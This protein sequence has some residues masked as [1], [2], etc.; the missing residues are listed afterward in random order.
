VRS[1]RCACTRG[2]RT[3]LRQQPTARA[4]GRLLPGS[5]AHGLPVAGGGGASC[6]DCT[7]RPGVGSRHRRGPES[8]WLPPSGTRANGRRLATGTQGTG[9]AGSGE[10][11]LSS[12]SSPLDT[13]R[14]RAR[15]RLLRGRSARLSSRSG[16]RRRRRPRDT[17]TMASRGGLGLAGMRGWRG[18]RRS[19]VFRRRRNHRCEPGPRSRGAHQR[20]GARVPEKDRPLGACA[21]SPAARRSLGSA[22][23]W[24]V[25]QR[26]CRL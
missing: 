8:R 20:G 14:A 5:R 1:P 10:A 19:L 3:R 16:A 26:E 24:Q 12:L 25:R 18:E 4:P 23:A 22:G 9:A 13:K 11:L 15:P 21:G 7:G 2:P 6:L 17:S